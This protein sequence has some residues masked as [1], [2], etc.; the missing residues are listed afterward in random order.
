M[1]KREGTKKDDTRYSIIPGRGQTPLAN[2]EWIDQQQ[3][4][5]RLL[6]IP[7]VDQQK[8]LF[9]GED[10]KDVWGDAGD[11]PASKPRSRRDEEVI[12]VDPGKRTAEDDLF[13][14]E[15]DLD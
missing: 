8:R 3:D 11:A 9:E 6:R 7:T 15:V 14:D 4:L 5:R 1:V 10:P 2:M 13:D 12:D